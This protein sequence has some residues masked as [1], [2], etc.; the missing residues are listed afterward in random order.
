MNKSRA[1]E[2]RSY[3]NWS[4][5][6]LTLLI[7]NS[8]LEPTD[9]VKLFPNRSYNSILSKR[10]KLIKLNEVYTNNNNKPQVEMDFTEEN[11]KHN[12]TLYTIAAMKEK[13]KTQ[14]V[15]T[16]KPS[17]EKNKN[18]SDEEKVYVISHHYL[19]I[20]IL[21]V[22]LP[23][24]TVGA[25]RIY[26]S[27]NG[28]KA[29]D[30]IKYNQHTIKIISEFMES[31][32]VTIKDLIELIK[33]V[34]NERLSINGIRYMLNYANENSYRVFDNVIKTIYYIK[35]NEVNMTITN[36][37]TVI[38]EDEAV[39]VETNVKPIV[40]T[41]VDNHI[42]DINEIVSQSMIKIQELTI[43]NSELLTQNLELKE[44]LETLKQEIETQRENVE[45]LATESKS[46]WSIIKKVFF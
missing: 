36:E 46:R 13:I 41:T 33:E 23:N 6:E 25:I 31:R 1:Y 15:K 26:L 20:N 16:Q 28:F 5:N 30:E 34:T 7:E 2:N 44:Q 18:W 24:R 19:P 4:K 8:H 32:K 9:L 45:A 27:R 40:N 38:K 39:T 3:V 29:V 43:K 12:G 14:K 21:K 35:Y 10:H 37:P 42:N 11:H 22:E 17:L